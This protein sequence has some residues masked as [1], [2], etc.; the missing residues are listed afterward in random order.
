MKPYG[1]RW[2]FESVFDNLKATVHLSVVQ[3][4]QWLHLWKNYG[5]TKCQ[6]EIGWSLKRSSN[7]ILYGEGGC[8]KCPKKHLNEGLGPRLWSILRNPPSNVFGSFHTFHPNKL[9][10]IILGE[11]L[12]WVKFL[13]NF[14]D[15]KFNFH[16]SQSHA[17]T[18]SWPTTKRLIKPRFFQIWIFYPSFGIKVLCIRTPIVWMNVKK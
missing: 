8:M 5:V 6:C 17:N 13:N 15:T 12:H 18:V 10:A 9:L 4:D 16:Q 3:I 7:L 14:H 1:L 11:I 2:N